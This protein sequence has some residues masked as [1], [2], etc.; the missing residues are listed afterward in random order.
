[1]IVEKC[2]PALARWPSRFRHVLCHGGLADIDPDLEQFTMDTGRTSER[3][4]NAHLANKLTNL[5]WGSW[6]TAPGSRFPA[7]VSSKAGT[8]PTDHGIGFDDL[9]RIQDAGNQRLESDEQQSVDRGR[10]DASRGFTT[11][12]INWCRSTR[13]SAC[14]DARDRNSPTSA[15]QISLQRLSISREHQ[16]IRAE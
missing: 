4:C 10:G 13:F 1:M 8:M 6:P 7:P 2:S 16:P 11:K 9:Q 5:S 14:S 15:D 12:H 3:V